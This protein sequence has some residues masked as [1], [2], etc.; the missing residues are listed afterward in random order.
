MMLSYIVQ[1]LVFMLV[2]PLV[3]GT[4]RWAKARLQR[5]QGPS[6]VQVY[7]DLLKLLS[8]RPVEPENSSWIF[9]GAPAVVLA[10]YAMLGFVMPVFYLPEARSS[11]AG[12]LLLL[13]YVLGLA[14]LAMGLA[15]MDS[16]AP[17]G[18]LGS[19]R[20]MF[21]H[22]LAE[23][24]LLFAVFTLALTR[25]TTDLTTI[26]W[27][28]HDAMPLDIYA[29]PELLLL[30]LAMGVLVALESGRLPIDNPGTH[31]E[32]TMLGKAVHLEYSGPRLALLEWAEALR[33]TFMLTL[34]LNLFGPR[35]LASPGESLLMNVILILLY[36]VKLLVLLLALALW[37]AVQVK[38]QL[39]SIVTPALTALAFTILAAVLVVAEHYFEM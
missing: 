7:R 16:G 28:N 34:L 33:L 1:G 35:L 31:L 23:P 37:E 30:M 3:A 25:N 15:G 13:V 22:V 14:R 2:A 12:D 24:T 39:R 17:F 21:V 4:L 20:E 9:R 10:C 26:I 6:P 8:K 29:A 32:L 5:R 18:G 27:A 11:P 38:A 36:P 19:S